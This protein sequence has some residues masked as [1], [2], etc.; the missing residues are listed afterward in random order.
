MKKLDKRK[1]SSVS[2][3]K[4]TKSLKV[5]TE[6]RC[7]LIRAK[8]I[9]RE[10]VSDALL[11]QIKEF[12]QSHLDFNS[13]LENLFIEK[14]RDLGIPFEREVYF[15]IANSSFYL[16]FFN[17]QDMVAVEIDG[18]QHARLRSQV[19]DLGR[20]RA[21]AF[22]GITTIRFTKADLTKD[23]FPT[24]FYLAYQKAKENSL[25]LRD[26][27]YANS[28]VSDYRKKRKKTYQKMK[29][30]VKGFIAVNKKGMTSFFVLVKP[31]YDAEFDLWL[32]CPIEGYRTYFGELL[33]GESFDGVGFHES[34][35][36][37][38]ITVSLNDKYI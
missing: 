20:D 25:K 15:N 26:K 27:T 29:V 17:G 16:D 23:D 33:P 10:D 18:M 6:A 22:I 1:G 13:Y 9:S 21:F 38:K 8:R 28:V 7:D 32:Y 36:P 12:R 14:T 11:E 5:Y 19:K 24:A 37:V 35:Y 3:S 30:T 31:K 4:N 2:I 34:P